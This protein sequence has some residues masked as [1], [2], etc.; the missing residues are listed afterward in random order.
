MLRASMFVTVAILALAGPATATTVFIN[1]P[2]VRI[3][4]IDTLVL[5]AKYRMSNTNFDL[6][7][8]AGGGTQNVPGGPNFISTN[9][10][11]N[12]SL[13]NVTFAFSLRHIAGQ[14]I[15]FSMTNPSNVVR[16]LAWGSFT[17]AL[18]TA[19]TVAAAQLL[20]SAATGE[21]PG[22]L[23]SPGQLPMN[24]LHLE[25][26]SLQRSGQN[27]TPVISLS[28]VAFAATGVTQQGSLITSQIVTPE[29]NLTNPNF[30]EV[31][32]GWASQWLVT[33]GNF[34]AFDWAVTGNVNM[35]YTGSPGSV[36]EFVKFGISGKQAAFTGINITGGVP[37]PS[38]W[39]MLIA[40]F[41]LVGAVMRRRRPALA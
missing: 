37:E 34:W 7:L 13:N 9:L 23:L 25:V 18:P 22:D 33:N 38:S 26:T 32:P 11:N 14:G 39:A 20:A 30:N 16:S 10:G 2:D 15:V 28:D 12:A 27:Y 24:T 8:D 29:T 17:P 35:A 5:G 36:D 21:T 3:T 19:P 41:G 4:A 31:G 6:S 1:D 40:G